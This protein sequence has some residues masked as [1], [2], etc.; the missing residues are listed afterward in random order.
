L[1]RAFRLSRSTYPLYDGEGAR[2]AGGRWNSKG[3][4]VVYMSEN[5]SLAILEVLVH[6]SGSLP[7]R[8]VLGQAEFSDDLAIENIPPEA[9]PNNWATLIP[10]EQTTMRKLG[11]EWVRQQRTA[12]LAVP[13][14]VSGERNYLLNPAHPA[15]GHIRFADPTHSVLTY[16]CLSRLGICCDRP[17]VLPCRTG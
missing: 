6:L 5:R 10:E 9:L 12:I 13:S 14:V 15:F 16:V 1:S 11:D 2:R 8:Y 17:V 7:D 4:R 3:V